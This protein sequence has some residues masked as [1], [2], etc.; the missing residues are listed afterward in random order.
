MNSDNS[1]VTI[2][3]LLIFF[4]TLIVCGYFIYKKVWVPRQ[5][6]AKGPDETSNVSTWVWDSGE[7]VANVCI[8]GFGDAA[9]GGLPDSSG[10]CMK[11]DDTT[12]PSNCKDTT[13]KNSACTTCKTGYGTSLS[14]APDSKG[15]CPSYWVETA[16]IDYMSAVNINIPNVKSKDECVSQ[17]KSQTNPPCKFAV[18]DT[19]TGSGSCWLKK[20]WSGVKTTGSSHSILAPVG[21]VYS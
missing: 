1:N 13:C 19:K 4:C 17:C 3:V 12:C 15:S 2:I 8:D 9:K 21:T 10:N 14:G 7:C 6:N 11:F 20:D 16:G 18:I 5:C